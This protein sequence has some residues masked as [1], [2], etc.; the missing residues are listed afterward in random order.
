VKLALKVFRESKV[1]R[2]ILGKLAL[3]VRRAS[4]VQKEP[5]ATKAISL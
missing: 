4:K 1:Q 3:K 2:V 5:K